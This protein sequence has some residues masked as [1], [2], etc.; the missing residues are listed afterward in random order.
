LSACRASC[1]AS[2]KF[3]KRTRIYFPISCDESKSTKFIHE[4]A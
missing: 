4:Y 2:H 3:Q 1:I